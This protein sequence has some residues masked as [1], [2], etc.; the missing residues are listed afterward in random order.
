[1]AMFFAFD[2]V[3]LVTFFNFARRWL[4]TG[5][6]LTATPPATMMVPAPTAA[7]EY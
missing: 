6:D 1:M 4:K 2:V 5:P 7:S 3:L